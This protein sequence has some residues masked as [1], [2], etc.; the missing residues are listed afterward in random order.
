MGM[1]L[2]SVA[3]VFRDVTLACLP[4][5]HTVAA[6]RERELSDVY[7]LSRVYFENRSFSSSGS[8]RS[9][10]QRRSATAQGLAL[11]ETSAV[12]R[13]R[14]QMNGQARRGGPDG[15]GTMIGRPIPEH[16][17]LAS[18]DLGASSEQHVDS[19]IATGPGITGLMDG[20]VVN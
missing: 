18:W 4:P 19:M 11:T 13:Q 15:L 8:R 6:V 5:G 9:L 2:I 1:G 12:A 7:F 17:Q 14:Q 20:E 3:G 16:D 10:T